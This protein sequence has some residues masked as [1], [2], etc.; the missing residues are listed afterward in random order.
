MILRCKGR[1]AYVLRSGGHFSYRVCSGRWPRVAGLKSEVKPTSDE[2]K[3]AKQR[4][5]YVSGRECAA[6]EGL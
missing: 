1:G 6:A 4:R 3:C 5:T 2:A